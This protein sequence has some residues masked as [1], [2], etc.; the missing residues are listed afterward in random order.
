M[1]ISVT[2][3]EMTVVS[4]HG[5]AWSFGPSFGLST[6]GVASLRRIQKLPHV[7]Y[8]PVSAGYKETH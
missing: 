2:L 6:A 4:L 7:R 3:M 1:I 5:K 8:R